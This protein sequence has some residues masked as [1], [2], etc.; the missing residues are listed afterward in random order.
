ME[1]SRPEVTVAPF[2]CLGSLEPSSIEARVSFDGIEDRGPAATDPDRERGRATL[3]CWMGS[4]QLNAKPTKVANSI[5]AY[6]EAA[7][8]ISRMCCKLSTK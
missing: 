6:E 1:I 3:C 5:A 8:L 7:V 2:Q 4:K